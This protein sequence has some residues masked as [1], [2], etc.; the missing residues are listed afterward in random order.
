[1]SHLN[2]TKE[3]Q[4]TSLANYLPG[5]RAFQQKI[6]AGS[7]LRK[8]L[9]GLASELFLEEGYLRTYEEETKPDNTVL[10]LDEWENAVGIPDDCF[11]GT[12]TLAE[13]RTHVLVKLA[14]LGVQ[15]EQDFIDLATL[16]GLTVTITPT[17]ETVIFPYTFPMQFIPA[18]QARFTIT[19]TF[20]VVV[21]NAFPLTF[22]IQFGDP[23]HAILTCLYKKL[24]PA[25]V[26]LI[27]I[28]V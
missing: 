12:G 20:A 13:R 5:G 23:Q 21:F 26:D 17:I 4:A 8:F 28:E 7:N 14:S 3:E 15:T 6:I 18:S 22:P 27:F 11:P 24:K 9:L 2:R 1:M 16:F 25:N 10:L 19:I